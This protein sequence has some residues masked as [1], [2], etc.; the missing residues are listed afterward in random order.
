MKK[1]ILVLILLSLWCNA[2]ESYKFTQTFF[3]SYDP[4]LV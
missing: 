4:S 2:F 3:G 1:N